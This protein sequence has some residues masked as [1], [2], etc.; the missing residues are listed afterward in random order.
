M[1]MHVTPPRS[2]I[3]RDMDEDVNLPST[4]SPFYDDNHGNAA[5]AM[6]STSGRGKSPWA[7]S[8][9]SMD[10]PPSSSSMALLP[11]TPP[12]SA[13]LRTFAPLHPKQVQR[14]KLSKK[15]YIQNKQGQRGYAF[16]SCQAPP[17]RWTTTTTATATTRLKSKKDA[18]GL[19]REERKSYKQPTAA[20][21]HTNA[22][23]LGQGVTD[24]GTAST[25]VTTTFAAPHSDLESP[26]QLQMQRALLLAS[27]A[28]AQHA[29]AAAQHAQRRSDAEAA[30]QDIKAQSLFH[31][32]VESEVHAD[33]RRRI[34]Q[35]E[36]DVQR[37]TSERN[38]QAH[39]RRLL[40]DENSRLKAEVEA[41]RRARSS[42]VDAAV[43]EG[44]AQNKAAQSMLAETRE[45]NAELNSQVA[46]LSAQ[47]AEL[48]S[49]NTVL[50][51]KLK[52]VEND[53]TARVQFAE[54]ELNVT[55]DQLNNTSD[56]LKQSQSV[57]KK[58]QGELSL[59]LETITKQQAQHED[60][61]A[62]ATQA[63]NAH[64]QALESMRNETAS[65]IVRK[66]NLD[67][68]RVATSAEIQA[69]HTRLGEAERDRA[70][71]TAAAEEA[72]RR[73]SSAQARAAVAEGAR[74]NA[75]AELR[76]AIKSRDDA[77]AEAKYQTDRAVALN[78][79]AET[80]ASE[81]DAARDMAAKLQ[82]QLAASEAAV[83]QLESEALKQDDDHGMQEMISSLSSELG[84]ARDELD[85]LRSSASRVPALEERAVEAERAR[86]D[87]EARAGTAEERCASLS[88]EIVDLEKRVHDSEARAMRSAEEILQ[89]HN[90]QEE[91][92]SKMLRINAELKDVTAE[93]VRANLKITT[94][95]RKNGH[96]EHQRIQR[97]KKQK[98]EAN[99][100]GSA[101]VI[102]QLNQQIKEQDAELAKVRHALEESEAAGRA[103][104]SEEEVRAKLADLSM[105][106]ALSE[107]EIGELT[108]QLRNARFHVDRL[109]ALCGDDIPSESL[110][111]ATPAQIVERY[112]S[113]AQ[114]HAS[115]VCRV[116]FGA[117]GATERPQVESSTPLS[118]VHVGVGGIAV[119]PHDKNETNEHEILIYNMS[120]IKQ[121][122]PKDERF[123]FSVAVGKQSGQ[124]QTRVIALYAHPIICAAISGSFDRAIA[125]KMEQSKLDFE[126]ANN[127]PK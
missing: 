53:R 114:F 109:K 111:G 44:R 29:A 59:A 123:V 91:S 94:L 82:G 112:S 119:E 55:S 108:L 6:N 81:R 14:K 100:A 124:E 57:L 9:T 87:A 1:E 120:S 15:T 40:D 16:G 34:Q 58:T 113:Q 64:R 22:S 3:M 116:A 104:Q 47:I 67:E 49:R 66:E 2:L 50:K 30:L 95:E 38:E 118:V 99:D 110:A 83:Q 90:D 33:L 85:R 20:E 11:A 103:S 4:S 126:G 102:D 106:F 13:S 32:S 75:D 18:A 72:D 93:L 10:S 121:Y 61:M 35:Q 79:A 39:A 62:A 69:L 122:V 76:S 78:L 127:T 73:A 56:L 52:H 80:A 63:V 48:N 54:E 77:V 25:S 71:A 36:L 101:A 88:Q 46:Q 74:A 37:V 115:F 23:A 28:A 98:E 105:K 70:N 92:S 96:L 86:R 7:D 17:P 89:R 27:T 51:K 97:D 5:M 8:S 84:Q 43:A 60:E 41:L 12:A 68:S 125:V 45:K 24:D 65:I 21:F 31:T 117:I 19:T 107:Q 42:E 26:Q